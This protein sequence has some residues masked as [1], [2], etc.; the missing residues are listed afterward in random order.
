MY[1]LCDASEVTVC[2]ACQ[3]DIGEIA[4]VCKEL[5]RKFGFTERRC[6]G[7][8]SRRIHIFSYVRVTEWPTL[9]KWLL[10]ACIY[11]GFHTWAGLCLIAP[12]AD[13]CFFLF[14]C[15]SCGLSSQSSAMG[16]KIT[17]ILLGFVMSNLSGH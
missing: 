3:R 4:D 9:G 16:C 7:T 15:L 13:Y 14:V 2:G 17:V 11:L 12:V 5:F 1:H 8:R 6:C 10:C